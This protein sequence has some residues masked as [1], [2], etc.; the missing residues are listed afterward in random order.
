MAV[1]EHEDERPALGAC[2]QARDEE[3]LQRGLAELRVERA[4]EVVVRQ[5]EPDE[6][7]EKRRARH[8]VGIDRAKLVLEVR[9]LG[10]LRA[11]VHETEERAPDL[12]PREVARRRSVGLAL[13]E[14]HELA[15][16]AGCSDELGDEPRLA[17]PRLG[18][19]PDDPPLAL[20][21]LIEQP[22][23][24]REL[25]GAAEHGQP[26]ADLTGGC[27]P[28][29]AEQCVRHYGLGLALRHERGQRL[30]RERVAC[31][32]PD[33]IRHVDLAGPAADISRAARFTASPRQT[34]VRRSA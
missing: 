11:V 32:H 2:A 13:P 8:E 4:G 15:A 25:V 22:P 23:E 21:R 7:T 27:P 29:R 20:D 26:V 16:S 18:G 31:R 1:L 17:E 5:R 9:D 3:I 19:D 34:N 28:R 12:P 6:L 14:R 10:V 30:P 24:V 33:G